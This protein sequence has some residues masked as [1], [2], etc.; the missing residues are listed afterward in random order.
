MSL[1]RADELVVATHPERRRAGSRAT[2][3]AGCARGSRSRCTTSSS[4]PRVSRARGGLTGGAAAGWLARVRRR[5]ARR[6]DA[7]RRRLRRPQ[8]GHTRRILFG[9]DAGSVHQEV[10]IAEL[11]PRGRR[12]A[13]PARVRGGDLRARRAARARVAGAR[14]E[15]A[16]TTTSS[17]TAAWRTHCATS[18][19]TTRAGSR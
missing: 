19:Q 8:R 5:E 3:S 1:F 4:T 13:S 18:P 2:S 6:R 14:E 17:S 11:E 12:R 15:L 10:V 9:R 7:R 16:A